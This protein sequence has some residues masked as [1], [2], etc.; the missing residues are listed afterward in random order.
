MENLVRTRERQRRYYLQRRKEVIKRLGNQCE[1]CG[2]SDYRVLQIAHKNPVLR[3]TLTPTDSG[4]MLIRRLF[5][6]SIE[7][8]QQDF[9][10]LCANDHMK[11]TYD[12][13]EW[14]GRKNAEA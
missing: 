4:G 9:R 10:L 3:K 12:R 8:L 7:K 5:F 14:S 1:V 2:E 13:N 6:L 11:E